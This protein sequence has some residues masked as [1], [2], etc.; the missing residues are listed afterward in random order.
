M[1]K[2]INFGEKGKGDI[3]PRQSKA[4]TKRVRREKG[5]Y[6]TSA[7]VIVSFFSQN[8]VTLKYISN[9]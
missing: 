2:L 1:V 9:C 4:S 6:M 8:K 7:I 3:I 5:Y